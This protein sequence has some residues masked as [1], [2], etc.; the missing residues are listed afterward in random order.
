[1][2]RN[3]SNYDLLTTK[4]SADTQPEPTGDFRAAWHRPIVTIIDIKRTMI[5][6]GAYLDGGSP[7]SVNS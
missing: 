4:R 2:N 1:M 6:S 5:G 7:T 3:K